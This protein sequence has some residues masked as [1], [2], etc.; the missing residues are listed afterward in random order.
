V[1]WDEN[2]GPN[3]VASQN[4]LGTI[5]SEDPDIYGTRNGPAPEPGSVAL[6][7]SGVLS[8]A[9]LLRKRLLG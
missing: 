4:T 2:D 8:L 3:S 1:G 6:F 9:G 7:G 5:G